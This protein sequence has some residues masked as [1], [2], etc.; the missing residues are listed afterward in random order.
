[1][2]HGARAADVI[3]GDGV[4]K[5]QMDSSDQTPKFNCCLLDSKEKIKS[6][7]AANN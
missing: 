4:R 2:E 1:M 3:A 5:N 6:I 7:F